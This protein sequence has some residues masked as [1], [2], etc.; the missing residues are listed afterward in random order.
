MNTPR[1]SIAMRL[2]SSQLDA[3]REAHRCSLHSLKSLVAVMP[4]SGAD[5]WTLSRPLTTAERSNLLRIDAEIDVL[6][7]PSDPQA[8]AGA[9]GSL[10][11]GFGTGAGDPAEQRARAAVYVAVLGEFPAWAIRD[12]VDRY[13][14]G[15]I[16]GQSTEFAPTPAAIAGHVRALLNDLYHQRFEVHRL[17]TAIEPT[18][19]EDAMAKRREQIGALMAGTLKPMGGEQ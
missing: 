15:K 14:R 19:S 10:W 2:D 13:L 8:V 6:L 18:M 16:P 1:N 12:T 4:E 11:L 9:L 17:K 5:R 3:L 7:Q